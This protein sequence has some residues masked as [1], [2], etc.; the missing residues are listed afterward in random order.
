MEDQ[1]ACLKAVFKNPL[2]G[3]EGSGVWK[4]E[5]APPDIIAY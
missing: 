2:K 3:A 4:G 5:S 1:R